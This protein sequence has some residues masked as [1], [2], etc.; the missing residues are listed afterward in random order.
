MSSGHLSLDVA[1]KLLGVT[2]N[3]L[4]RLA[5]DGL[6]QRQDKDKY[7]LVTLVRDYI[8]HLQA[9]AQRPNRRP[10][11][12]ELAEHL[13]MSERNLRDVLGAIG[14]DH[15]SSSRDEIRIGYIRHL[16]EQAAGRGTGNGLNL[17]EERAGLA[18]EQKYLAQLRKQQV[19]GE[20]A[21]IDNL[22]LALSRVTAQMASAMETIPVQLKRQ[23]PAMTAEQLDLV[24]EELARGRNLLVSVGVETVKTAAESVADYVDEYT[25]GADPGS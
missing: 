9:E 14:L 12:R 16:R 11:Q 7:P 1:A 3:E 17:A 2:P 15:R 24:R 6:V 13:D 4:D 25:D 10:S 5:R 19:L 23:F 21:P 20:W 18:R 22:T 8:A